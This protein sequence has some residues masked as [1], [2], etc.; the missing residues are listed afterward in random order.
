[1]KVGTDG[2]LLGAWSTLYNGNRI[3]DI[4]VGTGLISLMLSQRFPLA[5]IDAIEIDEDAFNQAEE[6]VLNSKFKDKIKV[7]HQTLQSFESPYKF[8]LIVSNPPFF[9]V[10]NKV[11]SDARK[12]ARQQETL[13]FD[14]LLAK[15]SQLLNIKGR[16]AFIIPYDLE[17]NFIEIGEKYKLYPCKILNIKG[18][19][20]AQFKRSII[21]M[22]FEKLEFK[23]EELIIEIDRYQYTEDYINLTKEFYLNM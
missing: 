5:L 7:Y 15:S 6:N 1:M 8:D 20:N 12:Q 2:V 23:R 11:E 14:E 10:N 4:G 13:T 3:L 17:N 16:A 19:Q 21:E 22:N 18:N 9:V